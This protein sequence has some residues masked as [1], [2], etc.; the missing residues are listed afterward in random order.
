[1][2]SLRFRAGVL[3]SAILAACAISSQAG[4]QAAGSGSSSDTGCD[5]EDQKAVV[6]SCAGIEFCTCADHCSG[7]S[8]CLSGCC[9]DSVCLPKCVCDGHGY[10]LC[11]LGE[12]PS[13]ARE[14]ESGGCSVGGLTLA[15]VDSGAWLAV[16]VV[17]VLAACGR[18]RAAKGG[19]RRARS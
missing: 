19:Q 2:G 5:G 16:G 9:H 14:S 17:A 12:Y 1:M 11:K 8:D 3:A 13:D 6:V 4:A 18:R 10:S 7:E 15:P